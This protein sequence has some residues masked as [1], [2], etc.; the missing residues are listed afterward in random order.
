MTGMRSEIQTAVKMS[1]QVFWVVKPHRFVG[2][3]QCCPEVRGSVFL[4]RA[5]HGGSMYLL[6]V[7]IYLQ[8]F[9][10]LKSRKPTS[11]SLVV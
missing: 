5:E 8:F 10:A 11:A 1:M 4:F 2:R 6:I 7:D 3:Q 9:R